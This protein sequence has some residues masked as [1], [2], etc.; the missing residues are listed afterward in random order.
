MTWNTFYFRKTLKNLLLFNRYA[1]VN[2]SEWIPKVKRIF[3]FLF[4]VFLFLFLAP[5]PPP[6]RFLSRS[7]I[8]WIS[9]IPF[10]IPC[11]SR[12]SENLVHVRKKTNA[13]WKKNHYTNNKISR[14]KFGKIVHVS[15]LRE[16]WNVFMYAKKNE[17]KIKIIRFVRNK[18]K[19]CPDSGENYM[20]KKWDQ[21]TTCFFCSIISLLLCVVPN[22]MIERK[23]KEKWNIFSLD[24]LPISN[25][26]CVAIWI[27]SWSN[28]RSY[29]HETKN[30]H[31]HYTKN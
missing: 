9:S 14:G 20:P 3:C 15:R 23:K 17:N 24:H 25:F 6:S 30:T 18:W 13:K 16:K 2:T 28:I 5:V 10:C 12:D 26:S 27:K 11:F 7:F 19:I 1:N 29:S 31:Q 22:D 4:L 21:L 8:F